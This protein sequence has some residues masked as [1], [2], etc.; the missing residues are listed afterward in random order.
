MAAGAENSARGRRTL[1]VMPTF[2]CTAECTH[3]GTL[4]SPREGTWLAETEMH[5]AIDQAA[6]L[7]Y[8]AVVF[9]GGEPM[10]A[11]E[12]VVRGIRRA[13]ERG[14]W[15]RVV[16]NGF[17]ASSDVAAEERVAALVG[18]GLCEINVS[19]G[20]QHARF[21]PLENVLRAVRAAVRAGVVT[22]IIVETVERRGITR[23]A[24]EGHPEF[25]RIADEFPH[26]FVCVQE[27]AWSPLSA[28]EVEQYPPGMAADRRN[29]SNCGGCDTVLTTTTVQ[30]DGTVS[31]CCGLGIRFVPEL[32]TGNI[33]EMTL[34]EADERA[35]ADP[36]K[37]LIR[38][39]GP[40][41]I[42]AWAAGHDPAIAW[43]G[44]YAHRCQACIRLHQDARVRELIDE[45]DPAELA[46]G[47]LR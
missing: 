26:A 17:W 28:G 43:E 24:V 39:I 32:R 45:H 27:W 5:S 34:A 36:L 38:D 42:L 19:T 37:R 18:G 4:S 1:C 30:A 40:E 9:T 46:R 25:R 29:L 21:V 3:C 14:M 33:R 8:A 12:R 13:A 41:R 15:V 23:A 11:G 35:A 22:T 47:A 2:R 10:L 7:G 44:L 31:P 6:E 16:T 20:D